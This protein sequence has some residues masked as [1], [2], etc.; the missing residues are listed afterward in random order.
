MKNRVKK[1]FT[2]ALIFFLMCASFVSVIFLIYYE[3]KPTCRDGVQNQ[4]E[5]GIDCGGPCKICPPSKSIKPLE[6]LWTEI[7]QSGFVSYDLV[8]RIKNSNSNFGI[9]SLNYKF[10]LY[11]KNGKILSEKNGLTYILPDC[12]KYIIESSIDSAVAPEKAV[13][14]FGHILWEEDQNFEKLNFPIIDRKFETLNNGSVT[15]EI[16]GIVTNDTFYDL[17]K[18]NINIVLFDADRRI[19][20]VNISDMATMMAEEKRYFNARWYW[21]FSKPVVDFKIEVDTNIFDPQ[22][23]LKRYGEGESER[24]N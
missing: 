23:I 14:K 4:G 7:I 10:V 24:Y 2:I 6:I 5:L 22:N 19:V 8:S 21:P 17:G 11:D 18:I 1:Q 13:L 12:E 3:P 16:S 9:G 15:G 20:G